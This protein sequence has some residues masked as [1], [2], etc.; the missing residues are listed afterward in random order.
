LGRKAVS[1]ILLTLLLTTM[2]MSTFNIKPVKAQAGTIY[3]RADGSVEPST[4]NITSVDNVTYTVTGNINESVVIERDNIVVDGAGY[5][6]QGSG[7]GAGITLSSRSNVTIRNMQVKAFRYGI[8]LEYS[9]NNSFSGN[10]M[11]DMSGNTGS[12]YLH[13]GFYLNSS[14]FNTISGN[15]IIDNKY[16]V[17][18]WL[19]ESSFNIIS[20]N[21]IRNVG[22]DFGIW[23]QGSSNNI[24]GNKIACRTHLGILLGGDSNNVTGNSI[25]GVSNMEYAGVE[26]PGSNNYIL[27][28]NI[29]NNF[30][31]IKLDG[32]LNTV[33]GNNITSNYYGIRFSGSPNNCLYQNNITGNNYGVDLG[34]SNTKFFHNNFIENIQQAISGGTNN[35]WDDGYPSAG[36]YWS[37]HIGVDLYRGQY[38]NE[39]GSDGIIDTAYMIDESNIDRYPL[40]NAWTGDRFVK[41]PVKG[42]ENATIM[43]NV[44]V[45]KALVTK[46]T[47]H[48]EASGS[49]GQTG[50]V[51]VI[52]PMINTTEIKVFING[53]KLTPPPYPIITTNGTH[54][55]IYFEFTLSTEIA[56]VQFW[57]LGD[58]SGPEGEQDCRVDVWDLEI[59]ASSFS[60]YPD[61]PRWNPIADL[62]G[63]L[64]LVPDSKVDIRDLFLIGRN[65]GKTAP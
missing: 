16:F 34:T 37:D 25:D 43:S 29:T 15:N 18:L 54:Y 50:W 6:L 11:T 27:G 59:I 55:F 62:T 35:T 20:E 64:Y 47:L 19:E 23:L 5:I 30:N 51:T 65:Y 24:V 61:H 8:Y 22:V 38:Q 28:N 41:V 10:N 36:N 32:S 57:L 42:G 56:T 3:I 4:A 63:L 9:S 48:F 52:F 26:V 45:T 13:Y 2:L 58:I 39:T 31:G 33:S 17:A 14:S 44:T 40:L 46:N 7:S 1:G 60:S 21:N 53:T 12:D 49:S